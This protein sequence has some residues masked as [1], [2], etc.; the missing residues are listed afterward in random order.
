MGTK[1]VSKYY[2][3]GY[4]NPSRCM[5]TVANVKTEDKWVLEMSQGIKDALRDRENG[6]YKFL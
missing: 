1:K 4:N 2:K 6:I 3:D 5:V